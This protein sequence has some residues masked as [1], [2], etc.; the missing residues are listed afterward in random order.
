M[1]PLLRNRRAVWEEEEVFAQRRP[2][3]QRRIDLGWPPG[4]IYAT[5]GVDHKL[6]IS[7]EGSCE[8]YDLSVDP[9]EI[10][11]ICDPDG[12]ESGKLIE[13]LN[14]HYRLMRSQ[15]EAMTSGAVPPEV[16]EELKALGYL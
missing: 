3:D 15:G 1:V 4:E 8:L 5:R 9:F 6:I 14:G 13:L 10:N 7:T 12:G 16:I 11:N 2:A